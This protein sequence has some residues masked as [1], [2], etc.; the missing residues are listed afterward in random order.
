MIHSVGVDIIEI[1]RIKETVKKYGKKFLNRIFT[2]KEI[3]YCESKSADKFSHYAVR[4]AAKEAAFK[5][6]RHYR[7]K[8]ISWKNFEV[9]DD[10]NGAPILSLSGK[11]KSIEQKLGISNIHLSLSHTEQT[12]FA[13]LVIEKK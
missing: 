2:Q 13:V 12:A 10:K 9:I 3:E 5:A 7:Q 4:F 11:A 6:F 8:E 1:S